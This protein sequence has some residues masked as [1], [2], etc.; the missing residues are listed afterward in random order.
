[1]NR[2]DPARV[3]V[4]HIFGVSSPQASVGGVDIGQFGVLR[5]SHPHDVTTVVG[6]L[7]KRA[8]LFVTGLAQ[9]RG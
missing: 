7:A 8:R 4:S 6:E 1:V 3:R 2:P 9:R 5:V